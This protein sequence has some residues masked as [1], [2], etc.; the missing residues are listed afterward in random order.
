MFIVISSIEFD[1]V[2]AQK[3]KNPVPLKNNKINIMC[4]KWGFTYNT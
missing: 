3:K 2:H 1:E 4:E